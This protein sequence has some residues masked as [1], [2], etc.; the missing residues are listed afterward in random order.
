MTS[1]EIRGKVRPSVLPAFARFASKHTSD[2]YEN[3]FQRSEA[4]LL[5]EQ[6][7]PVRRASFRLGRAAAH[8]A[9]EQL[10]H[11]HGAVGIGTHR[12]PLWPTGVRG[13]ISHA[14]DF[15]VALVAPD[16]KTDGIGIDLEELR[17]APELADQVPRPEEHEWLSRL[18][19]VERTRS[20]FALFSAKE[21]VFKAFFPRVG[22]FFGFEAA[23]LRLVDGGFSCRLATEGLDP[24]YPSTRE[25]SVTCDWFDRLVLTTL[26]LPFTELADH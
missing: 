23:S 14:G 7:G 1:S 10:G 5:G 26:V 25:F 22:R 15:A 13:S 16:A 17:A 21:A 19:P 20:L 2:G 6:A 4:G 8:D 9:L 3:R 24:S 11:N 18:S 12:Q